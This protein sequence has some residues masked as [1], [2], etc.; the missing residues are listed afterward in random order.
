LFST[1]DIK[2]TASGSEGQT[3]IFTERE[4]YKENKEQ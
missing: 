3:K 2:A 4:K 1:E